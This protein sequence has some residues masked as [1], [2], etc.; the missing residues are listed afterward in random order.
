MKTRIII[1]RIRNYSDTAPERICTTWGRFVEACQIPKIRGMLPLV[2][3]LAAE[4]SVRD[5]Q[6]DG[7][8]II[9]GAF[10]RPGTRLKRD[11]VS[12]SLVALDFDDGHYT[13]DSLC[14]ALDGLEAVV[15]TSYSHS[16][17]LRKFR[18]YL[19][20]RE[21]VTGNLENVLHRI[22]DYFSEAIGHIDP[23]CRKPNQLFYCP[24]VPPGSEAD[25]QF[26][27]LDGD[28]IS[29]TDF[30]EV[31]PAIKRMPRIVRT[32]TSSLPGDRFN[33]EVDWTELL[34]GLGW[35]YSHGVH[36][37]R[38]GKKRGISG[39]V[40]DGGFYVHSSAPECYPL[41][42]GKCYTAF[43]IVAMTQYDGDYS[44]AAK[45]LR[46]AV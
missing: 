32:A 1:S 27:Y 37:T 44:R 16:I 28:R 21:T 33:A 29:A 22:M 5:A 20:L 11:M 36:W 42:Q 9:A 45:A 26:R 14:D 12:L 25:Y 10:S 46:Q 15:F 23:A 18:A 2:S 19:P 6:K 7:T 39:S 31:E 40:L 38:P 17:H 30:P 3:Y 4:K 34:T 8:A 13:F 41:E 43:G 35:R 24:A